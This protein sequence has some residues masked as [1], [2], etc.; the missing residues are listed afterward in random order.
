MMTSSAPV[1]ASLMLAISVLSSGIRLP[2]SLI[3]LETLDDRVGVDVRDISSDTWGTSDIVEG[4][5]GDEG[6]SLQEER[7]G[8]TNTTYKSSEG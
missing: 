8:L 3:L 2:Y 6:V 1:K 7:H 4:E 5:S